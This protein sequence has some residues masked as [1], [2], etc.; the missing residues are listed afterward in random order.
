VSASLEYTNGRGDW[1]PGRASWVVRRLAPSALRHG[2]DSIRDLTASVHVNVAET[3]T[4]VLAVYRLNSAF[5][6]DQPAKRP[7]LDNR[8]NVELRQ[9]LPVQ[10][11][12]EGTLNFLFAARTLLHDPSQM[13]S[14][15]D[16]LLTVRPPLRLTSGVQV[17]F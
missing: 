1:R 3:G 14:V 17:E 13:P 4:R 9:Q 15:Y 6:T 16:E 5:S 11:F 8:I 7:G 12:R 2:G 10:P